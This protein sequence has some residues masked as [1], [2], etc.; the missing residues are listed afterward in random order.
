M[1]LKKPDPAMF[2][3]VLTKEGVRPEKCIL[4]DDKEKNVSAARSMGIRFFFS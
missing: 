1:E 4:I 2:H 3:S